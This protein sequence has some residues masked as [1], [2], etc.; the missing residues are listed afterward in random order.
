MI[1]NFSTDAQIRIYTLSGELV[2][3]VR[4]NNLGTAEWDG[5]N[6][7]GKECAS[8]VYLVFVESNGT[9]KKFK[10]GIQR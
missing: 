1:A 9:S 2:D 6:Q 7:D 8:G 3:N 4:A 5:R 10:V